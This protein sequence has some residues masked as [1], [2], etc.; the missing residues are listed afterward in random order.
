VL[1]GGK[2]DAFLVRKAEKAHGTGQRIEG[3]REKGA[4]VVIVED[5]CTTGGSTIQALQAAREIGFQ[6]VGVIC[7]VDREEAGGRANVEREASPAPFVAI[8][9]ARDLRDECL[10]QQPK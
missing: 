1:S 7:L 9:T 8:F 3:F 6:V 5:V 2:V 4:R 10:K